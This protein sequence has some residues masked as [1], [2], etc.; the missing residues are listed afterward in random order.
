[1]ALLKG[2]LRVLK[3]NECFIQIESFSPDGVFEFLNQLGYTLQKQ[4]GHDYFF[5][6]RQVNRVQL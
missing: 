3:E 5:S 1:M 6:R 2:A 4:F